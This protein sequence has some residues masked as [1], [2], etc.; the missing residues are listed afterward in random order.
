MTSLLACAAFGLVPQSTR[1][2]TWPARTVHVVIPFSLGTGSPDA[3][4]RMLADGLGKRW[5]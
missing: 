2:D 3:A 4:A 1:A 5:K